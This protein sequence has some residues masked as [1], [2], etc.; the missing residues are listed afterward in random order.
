MGLLLTWSPARRQVG[1]GK[2]VWGR[3]GTE[4]LQA[5]PG[6]FLQMRE[7]RGWDRVR[8]LAEGRADVPGRRP[9]GWL[10][11]GQVARAGGWETVVLPRRSRWVKTAVGLEKF[12]SS[13][14]GAG[15]W[16]SEGRLERTCLRG[17]TELT[18]GKDRGFFSLPWGSQ[19]I[20]PP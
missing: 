3:G 17:N 14:R 5:E 19:G 11:P 8:E 1:R 2:R 7:E 9:G 20:T 6:P 4:N 18:E 12:G 13:G 16:G 15:S 10:P